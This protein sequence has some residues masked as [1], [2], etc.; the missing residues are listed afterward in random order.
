[1]PLQLRC[2]IRS[3]SSVRC[4]GSSGLHRLKWSW[5]GSYLAGLQPTI[6][7]PKAGQHTC[8]VAISW[9]CWCTEDLQLC[10]MSPEC[11]MH[12]CA[13]GKASDITSSPCVH[14]P[15]VHATSGITATGVPSQTYILKCAVEQFGGISQCAVDHFSA[16]FVF[17]LPLV[18]LKPKNLVHIYSI[19]MESRTGSKMCLHSVITSS[20]AQGGGGSFKKR[21]TIGEIGCCESRM[22]KQKHW[23]TD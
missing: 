8:E 22:S 13:L 18:M 1:M 15:H 2:S 23:P 19:D 7:P 14:L 21:K 16:C 5:G 10:F 12:K 9:I 11:C 17:C 6:E 20:T 3:V 4:H